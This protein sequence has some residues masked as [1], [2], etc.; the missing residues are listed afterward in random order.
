MVRKTRRKNGRKMKGGMLNQG[1]MWNQGHRRTIR[2]R[3][4]LDNSISQAPQPPRSHF[5]SHDYDD[6]HTASTNINSVE[7]QQ[8]DLRAFPPGTPVPPIRDFYTSHRTFV[9]PQELRNDIIQLNN[10]ITFLQQEIQSIESQQEIVTDNRESDGDLL[11]LLQ[12][13]QRIS[14]QIQDITYRLNKLIPEINTK[15]R[16]RS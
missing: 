12:E 15:L 13:K 7:L 2:K 1:R 3:T 6:P 16:T 4:P 8:P 9:N 14:I 10:I 5:F 11:H